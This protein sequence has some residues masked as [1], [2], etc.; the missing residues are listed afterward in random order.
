MKTKLLAATLAAL[1]LLVGAVDTTAFGDGGD[2]S[3]EVAVVWHA[4]SDKA[5][6]VGPD[7]TAS[8]RRSPQGIR[9]RFD[10]EGLT[11][12]HAY[13]LWLVVV[14][15]PGECADSP[16]APPTD[17]IT[18]AA[19][20]SQITFADAGTVARR[21][22]AAVLRAR[23]RAAPLL[24]GW[25]PVQGLD[26]PMG[27]EIHLVLNDHGP[28]I[29]QLREEMTS[30]YRAGCTD[31]SLPPFFPPTA[32]ADGTPGPNTCRLYQAAV[33]LPPATTET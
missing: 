24:D 15:D 8:L 21:R 29:D 12:G 28:V 6:A 19:T 1:T 14:N 33:F 27:A 2:V 26:D 5:G 9:Y 20:D 23:F 25:L 10:T 3:Q 17:I 31:A 7:A 30:S 4:Q 16:C 18:N 13:T 32:F 22:G 11:P